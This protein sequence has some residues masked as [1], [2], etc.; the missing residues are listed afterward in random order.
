MGFDPRQWSSGNPQPRRITT[1]IDALLAENDALRRE[2]QQL[3]RRLEQLE[4]PPRPAGS[5]R[6]S[7][8]APASPPP[9]PRVTPEQVQRWGEAL[10]GQSGWRELRLGDAGSGLQGVI[11]ELNRRSF[12]PG[13]SLEQ[14]L[15]R[16]AA[17]LG[18]DLHQALGGGP[19][20]RK[21]LA[22]LAA[23]ALYGP[24]AR[25]WLD[26]APR[27][28]VEELRQRQQQLERAGP[29][30]RGRRTSTDQRST[31]RPSGDQPDV[32]PRRRD[33]LRVLGLEWGASR[34]AIKTAHR[35]LVKQHHPDM[36]GQ[37]EDF[38]RINAAYQL[39]MA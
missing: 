6:W 17:G 1:N 23:F 21:R 4:R 26:D 37:A 11:Q 36:G 28:V 3:R 5:P 15:D 19:P 9:P 18:R 30:R 35:R 16:L 14:R 22:I 31:D 33:A 38:H 12:H 39:L 29:Q 27:R 13:L 25:E 8:A 10:A 7:A 24:S 2:V 32:D 34:Q 20:S